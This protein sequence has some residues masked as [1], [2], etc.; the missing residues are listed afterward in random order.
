MN[1]AQ[2]TS[3]TPESDPGEQGRLSTT[4]GH[5]VSVQMEV[6]EFAYPGQEPAVHSGGRDQPDR[7]R[8]FYRGHQLVQMNVDDAPNLV[9]FRQRPRVDLG[10]ANFAVSLKAEDRSPSSPQ[11]GHHGRRSQVEGVVSDSWNIRWARPL[12]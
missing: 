2:A 9:S 5:H 7:C 12:P 1:W 11:P 3:C 10:F 4:G 8:K 6:T